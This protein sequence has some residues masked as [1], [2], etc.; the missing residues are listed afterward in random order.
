MTPAQLDH[1][2]AIDEHLTAL[3]AIAE[4]RTP[5]RWKAIDG[6]KTPVNCGEKHIAMVNYYKSGSK[7]VD[8]Y[9]DEH[10][11][12]AAFIASCAGNAEAGWKYAL[13]NLRTWQRAHDEAISKE[14]KSLAAKQLESILAAWPLELL[15][16]FLATSAA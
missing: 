4:K 6:I 10:E 12:N 8:V 2:R 11:A 7:S 14:L 1:L 9:G 3:L 16:I 13:K 5:G 15:K